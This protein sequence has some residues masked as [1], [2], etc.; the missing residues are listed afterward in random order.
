[1]K[2]SY[3]FGAKILEKEN[4]FVNWIELVIIHS[5]VKDNGTEKVMRV[6]QKQDSLFNSTLAKGTAIHGSIFFRISM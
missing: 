3:N 5:H 4:Q 6:F 2:D 1:M